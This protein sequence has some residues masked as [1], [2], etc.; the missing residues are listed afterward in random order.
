MAEGPKRP[1]LPEVYRQV[2]PYLGLGVEFA[3]SVLL[4]LFGGR[5][6]DSKMGTEPAFMLVG[7]LLGT[8]AGFYSFFRKALRLGERSKGEDR[9]GGTGGGA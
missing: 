8:A 3:A 1:N 7:V 4:C 2:G 5:W 9:Q 6:L